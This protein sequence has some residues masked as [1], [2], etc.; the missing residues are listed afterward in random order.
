ME[1]VL[2]QSVVAVDP[3]QSWLRV[4]RAATATLLLATMLAAVPQMARGRAWLFEDSSLDPALRSASG[5]TE[6]IVQ[7]EPGRMDDVAKAVEEVGGTVHAGLPLVDGMAATVP[8]KKLTLLAR[9][10]G[11]RAVSANHKVR[12]EEY[13][14]DTATTA[15]N[16]AKASGATSAWAAGN[17]GAGVG[18]AVIDTG[19]SPMN[20]FNGRLV[21][22]P[23]L[24]GEGT[25][26]DTYGHGT[27]MAG[28]IGG[29]GADSALNAGG[30]YT[31]VAPKSHIV[32]VKAAG[33]NG[34]ADV[35]TVLQAMHWVASYKAQFNIRVLNLSWGTPSKQDPAYDPLNYAVQRLW[36]Q[37]IVV[38]VAAGNSGPQEGT[39]TKPGD[40]PVILSVGAYDDK[41]TPDPADDNVA[42]WSSRG[43]VGGVARPDIV[44][45]GRLIVA[46][47]SY[48]SYVEQSNPKAL[49]PP[50]Y[51]RGSGTSQA[52]AVVSGLAAL[53][54]A[55]RPELTPDQVKTMLKSSASPIAGQGGQG[56]GRVSFTGAMSASPG[57]AVSQTMKA[58]GLGSIDASRGGRYIQTDCGN[59]GTI[60]VIQ[61]EI[62]ARCEAW[63]GAAWTGAA[64][65]GA[66]WTG[67]AWTGAAWTGAAW[68]GGAWTGAAWTGA[69]WTGGAWTGGAWT[70][71]AWTGAAW[72]GGAWT[73]AAWTGAAWTGAAWTG[74]AWTGGAWT[75]AEYDETEFLTAFWGT[76]TPFTKRIPGEIPEAPPAGFSF[77]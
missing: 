15:S 35:T 49:F 70:G 13:S 32:S 64:W 68:T 74:G 31:G 33:R 14:Y 39:I 77:R 12:F 40:D 72:T 23:D 11:V 58:N 9:F 21:H 41:Q 22:G 73:G 6:V 34:A 45:P 67:A 42:S 59:N 37:G 24:S 53:M 52:A 29:S 38:V 27:V 54:I 66:A 36:Q 65:T 20:D 55:A 69:A 62:D 25:Y 47:R 7:A 75:T 28:V 19:V 60:E 4:L 1:V 51:I 61:G 3:S 63:N 16:F 30:A 18:V 17:L 2:S 26:V 50:S 10:E 46:S 57:A 43:T 71:A 48:G 8:A 56:A 5:P 76:R 44:A